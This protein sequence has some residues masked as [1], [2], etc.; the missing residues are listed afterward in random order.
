MTALPQ[1]LL[2]YYAV[3]LPVVR[4]QLG[5]WRRR[6]AAVPDPVLRRQAETALTE[7]ARN[8]EAVAVFAILA[9][10]R[11]RRA[12]IRAIIALQVAIDYLDLLGEAEVPDPLADGLQLHTA[13][14]AAATPGAPRE[15]WYR[16][17][18]QREDGGYL[19]DL[20]LACQQSLG[21]LPAAAALGP[22]IAVAARRC[23]EGQS[24]THAAA[25][26]DVAALQGWAEGLGA[27]GEYHWW[28]VAA[29]A[30]SSVAAH[31]LIAA[32]ADPGAGAEQAAAIDDVYF[33]TVGALTV[34]LDDLVDRERDAEGGEH[35]YVAYYSSGEEAGERLALIAGGAESAIAA[36]PRSGPHRA[37]LSGVAGFY[38][39]AAEARAP[40]ARPARDRLLRTCGPGARTIAAAMRLRG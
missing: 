34:L 7:K 28:E 5:E 40:F 21:A 3:V 20:V 4:R 38:L 36:L 11:H 33:P 37:I 8:P 18:P 27:P 13:L 35:N 15:D 22:G 14:A 23:G 6:A 10:R 24:H 9:P 16:L 32:A 2:A 25:H 17:H 30:S 39:G 19:E 12:A 1:A 31:A 26:G 29:G